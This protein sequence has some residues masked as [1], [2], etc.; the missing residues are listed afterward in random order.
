MRVIVFGVGAIGGVIAGALAAKGH[1]VIGIARG[2]RLAALREGMTLRSPRGTQQVRFACAA[3]PSEIAFRPGDLILLAVKSQDTHPALAALR[4]AGVEE[5]PIFCAQNGVANEPAALRYF[6][7]VHGINV[8]L[9]AEYM[10]SSETIAY[11]SPNFGV[12]DIGR[13]PQGT[14][15]ADEA[16][17]EALT[18]AGIAGYPTPHVMEF[19]YGK[20]IQNLG[21]IVEAALGYGAR[22]SDLTEALQAEGRAVLDRIGLAWRD[23]GKGDPRRQ[24]MKPGPVD[25]ATRIGSSSTQSLARG[26]GSI[27]TD[28]LNGEIVLLGRQHGIATPA[29]AYATRLAARLA[30]EKRPPGSVSRAEFAAG[31]GLA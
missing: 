25:G 14:D 23:V 21:N 6:P 9:P 15:R 10:T 1:D 13:Y 11:C 22:E 3:T 16:L 12:F 30:R 18:G 2:A 17:A 4:A 31:I 28:Y 24:T 20:V 19:K 8:M 27:E 26:A 7:N 29:N 5:Q